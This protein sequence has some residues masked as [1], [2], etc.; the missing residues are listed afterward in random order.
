MSK[1]WPSAT[2][3]LLAVTSLSHGADEARMRNL[4]NRVTS[5]ECS[6]NNCCVINPPARP[7]TPDCWGLYVAVTPFIWQAN[8]NGLPIAIETDGSASFFND[9]GRN[10]VRNLSFDWDWGVKVGLGLNTTHDAWDILLEW[11]TW[12]TDARRNFSVDASNA[13][14]PSQG[15]P[16]RTFGTVTRRVESDWEMHYN[17][18]DLENGR[19]FYVSRCM[20]LR[21]HAGLRTAWIKQELDIKYEDIDQTGNALAPSTRHDVDKEDRSW[22][23]GIRGGMDIQWTLGCNFSLFSNFAGS[24][25][26]QYHSL[27]NT[28]YSVP[29]E[30]ER[31][32]I[33]AVDN[34]FHMTTSI[35]DMELG[36][37][38]AWISCSECYHL[39]FD[40]GWEQHFHSGQN[41]FMAFM[42]DGMSGKFAVNQGDLGI[43][44]W[45]FKIRFDF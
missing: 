37:R 15:H 14:Y 38:F 29:S 25:L 35:F 45:F 5:L 43:Q 42:D 22:G 12:K 32:R 36:L 27:K 30:D 7:Y 4:E 26:Y 39:G 13:A 31:T 8:E 11:T 28:E 33:F 9:Q 34:F 24:L 41:E 6:Q 21:P 17:I 19:D 10:K 18:L 3:S 1:F 40:L 44:G 20:K 23:M 16:A 2:L